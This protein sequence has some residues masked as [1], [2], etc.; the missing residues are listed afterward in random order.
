M[1][2]PYGTCF[3]QLSACS[4]YTFSSSKKRSKGKFFSA[5]LPPPRR[6]HLEVPVGSVERCEKQR[7]LRGSHSKLEGVNFKF[8]LDEIC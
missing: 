6:A 2:R 7:V 1:A 4:L 3:P 8:A 5:N